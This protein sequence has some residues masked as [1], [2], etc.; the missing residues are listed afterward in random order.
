MPKGEKLPVVPHAKTFC[1]EVFGL[2]ENEEID[3][4]KFNA[5][6]HEWKEIDETQIE[7][8]GKKKRNKFFQDG[9]IIGVRLARDNQDGKDD[10]QTE[11]DKQARE[12]MLRK[13]REKKETAGGSKR[14]EP[15]GPFINLGD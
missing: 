13:R 15:G 5:N 1:R 3:I 7:K 9:D 2:A 6:E 4:C 12:E 11:A 10:F 14:A 8:L